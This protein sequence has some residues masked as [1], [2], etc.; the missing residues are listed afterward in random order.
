MD[1]KT[2]GK[3][4]EDCAERFLKRNGYK[5]L[6]RNWRCAFG[7]IDIVAREKDF[8]AFVEIK[9]RHSV[10]FGPGYL[11]VNSRKQIKLINLGQAYLKRYGLVDK[12]CRIDVVSINLD[13]NNEAEIEL[14][15]DAFWER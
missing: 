7:E 15:K 14:I 1:N 6:H 2:L 9:T 10:N 11:S 13:E 3:I 12:P 8:I 5:I 4:G